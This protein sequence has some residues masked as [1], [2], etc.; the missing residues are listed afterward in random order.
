MI[1]INSYKLTPAITATW[2]D[3]TGNVSNQEDLVE[4][5]STHG[6]GNAAW[7][8]ISGNISDQSDLMSTLGSYATESWV[9]S[10]QFVTESW[11]SEQGY[12]VSDDLSQYAT[13]Q[14]VTGRGYATESWVSS[15]FISTTVL[16]DY[17]LKSNVSGD[18]QMNFSPESPNL[19]MR[20]ALSRQ[21]TIN[22]TLIT[23][24]GDSYSMFLTS[25]AMGLAG[26]SD[27]GVG[28]TYG[29]VELS[30][31]YTL[32]I[33]GSESNA[34]FIGL[35]NI[36]LKES[37]S[38]TTIPF[39]N[40]KDMATQSWVSSQQF[41]TETYVN[42]RMFQTQTAL[43]NWVQSQG[44]ITSSGLTGYATESWVQ[45]Q[46]YVNNS[47]VI[48]IF[49]DCNPLVYDM[50]NPLVSNLGY[51]VLKYDMPSEDRYT[52]PLVLGYVI[53]GPYYDTIEVEGP[54]LI[55]R[56]YQVTFDSSTG[57]VTSVE[58]RGEAYNLTITPNEYAL[59]GRYPE[60]EEAGSPTD[61][62]VIWATDYGDYGILIGANPTGVDGEF[63]GVRIDPDGVI[64]RYVVTGEEDE[65][66]G[67]MTYTDEF[68][69]FVYGEDEG[70]VI[71]E[72]GGIYIKGSSVEIGIDEDTNSSGL[73]IYDSGQGAEIV[74]Y[75]I[76]DDGQG[77]LTTV[78]QILAT[79]DWVTTQINNSIGSAMSITN[80]ILS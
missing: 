58:Q 55:Q 25:N 11:V 80:Q 75:R 33:R 53:N 7:G 24:F 71:D 4:Y 42:G 1:H 2:G 77:N 49:N 13:R 57:Q 67:E 28:M 61:M 12:L 44:Y 45:S 66:T 26:P 19:Y 30:S 16:S 18:K 29:P 63:E 70:R 41:A 9:S 69:P 46:G 43:Q 39:S 14:W 47:Q 50:S 35:D 3:I 10:Q 31:E 8:S 5:I 76:N 40:L 72:F 64:G 23:L 17:L 32:T 74:K 38:L 37:G 51:S 52:A 78:E 36:Y 27:I 60:E 54:L 62:G 68:H 22:P 15:N 73:R 65:G 79:Q 59:I 20:N 21:L 34:T 56:N 6:G 48:S